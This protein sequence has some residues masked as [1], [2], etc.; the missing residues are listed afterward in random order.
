MDLE[1]A[2]E[3]RRHFLRMLY[4]ET[5]GRRFTFAAATDIRDKLGL[6]D[7]EFTATTDYLVGRGWMKWET[8]DWKAS[9]TPAGVEEV[10]QAMAAESRQPPV[11]R[12]PAPVIAEIARAFDAEYTH[13]QIDNLFMRAGAPG[14]PPAGSKLRKV[15][16]WLRLIDTDP[17]LD[18]LDV[19]GR[20]LE[21]FME[22]QPPRLSDEAKKDWEDRHTRVQAALTARG[23]SYHV[24]GK[25]LGGTGLLA[26]SKTLAE[27]IRSRDLIA[28]GREFADAEDAVLSNPDR[29]VTASCS[30]LESTCHTYIAAENL[31]PPS[32]K[33]LH[34]LWKVVQ[35]HLRIAPTAE[36]E[37]D[38]KRVLGGLA[39]I[40]DG[41]G[42]FRTHAGDA[43]GRGPDAKPIEARHARL[44]VHAAHTVVTFILETWDAR[45]K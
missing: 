43:H 35:R 42:A 30:I 8:L 22:V 6:A 2:Q 24:G 3:Q 16:E 20:L 25:I 21:E 1:R 14:E 4:E 28:I 29:A 31:T 26:A 44:A 17:N 40:V 39:S 5:G 10:E 34:S 33:S 45:R 9:I 15:A 13:A 32:D 41:V 7:D 38:L 36:L 19:L 23:L 11:P 27:I 18:A 37:E 12:I